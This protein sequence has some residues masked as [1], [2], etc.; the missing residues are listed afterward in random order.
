MKCIRYAPFLDWIFTGSQS[1]FPLPKE[2]AGREEEVCDSTDAGSNRN[3]ATGR[4][5]F[6]NLDRGIFMKVTREQYLEMWA[7]SKDIPYA[8]AGHLG[9]YKCLLV[10]FPLGDNQYGQIWRDRY[11]QTY[12]CIR[13]G[14]S[15]GCRK[16][17]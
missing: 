2:G 9:K 5:A 10:E 6:G 13:E 14:D 15:Q 16:M 7:M 17:G 1:T 12:H 8:E 4:A 3:A 11:G